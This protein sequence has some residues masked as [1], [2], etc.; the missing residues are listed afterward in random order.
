MKNK[1]AVAMLLGG[2]VLLASSDALAKESCK[3][4]ETLAEC[5]TRV[6]TEVSGL[7]RSITTAGSRRS[8]M[9]T[10]AFADSALI[11]LAVKAIARTLSFM[12][13]SCN[14]PRL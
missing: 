5:W 8:S 11:A 6:V 12:V 13:A 14:K 9:T 4:E 7:S 2:L 1:I 3:T 10:C